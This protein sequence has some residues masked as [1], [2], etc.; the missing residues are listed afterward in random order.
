MKRRRMMRQSSIARLASS[1]EGDATRLWRY[2]RCRGAVVVMCGWRSGRAVRGSLSS[3]VFC[4]V[5]PLACRP[6]RLTSSAVLPSTNTMQPTKGGE[7]ATLE[8]ARQTRCRG[9]CNGPGSLPAPRRSSLASP[10]GA[11]LLIQFQG[12]RSS[13]A[14]AGRRTP[15]A[16][17][18]P[19][20]YG[21]VGLLDSKYGCTRL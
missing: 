18:R 12:L 7:T 4:T 19:L 9:S 16:P 17:L 20:A 10:Q 14:A 15:L 13:P 6:P 11:P 2:N 1:R 8:L 3:W 21:R 5:V